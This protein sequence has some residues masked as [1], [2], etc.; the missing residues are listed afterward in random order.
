MWRIGVAV[1][2]RVIAAA[3]LATIAV[4]AQ[5]FRVAIEVLFA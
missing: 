4:L 2:L 1:S 3:W 5:L